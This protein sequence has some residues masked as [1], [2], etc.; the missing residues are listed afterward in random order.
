MSRV[1]LESVYQFLLISLAFLFPLTVSGGSVVSV[2]ILIIWLVSGDYRSKFAQIWSNK[3]SRSCLAFFVLH[4]VGLF[5]TEDYEWGLHITKKMWY[6]TLL[7]PILLTLTR[8]EN[9]QKYISAFLLAM[10]FS[11]ICSYLIWF[12]LISP[13]KKATV[14]NPTPFVNHI[15]YNPLLAFAIYLLMYEF[16][17]DKT[18]SVI[19]RYT[20]LFFA[21]SMSINMFITGGRAGH[22][23]YFSMLTIL[24][25][26]YFQ[27]RRIAAFFTTLIII[28]AVFISAYQ[29]SPIFKQR[30]ESAVHTVVDYLEKEGENNSIAEAKTELKNSKPVIEARFRIVGTGLG[31]RMTFAI[32]SWEIFK[33]NP[34]FG[35]GTGDFPSEYKA[36]SQVNTPSIPNT[37]NPHNMY[38]LEAVQFGLLGIV[39]FL[40]IFYY[41][42]KS[43]VNSSDR[44][45]RDVGVA[46][47]ALFM[48]ISLA[49]SYLL[50]HTTSILFVICSAFLYSKDQGIEYP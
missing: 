19:R 26:Q 14:G 34:L 12:E 36:M 13:F 39:G 41:Q 4:V 6:L 49:D 15:S 50:G 27:G 37:V 46:L 31:Q 8:T 1:K 3:L 24:V 17:I 35:V 40:A 2:A 16:L 20:Y 29:L 7:L 30:T 48:I 21:I 45:I 33:N 18:L 44:F 43:A 47:P 10:T 38:S 9:R 11:E 28:P 22:V 5:W 23:M 42:F 25:F 32:N